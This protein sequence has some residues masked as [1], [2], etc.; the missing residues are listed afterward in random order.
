MFTRTR[1]NFAALAAISGA[2]LAAPVHAQ[3]PQR[4]EV[5]GSRIKR[6]NAEL[7]SPVETITA[8]D[9]Q[10]TGAKTVLE[11]MRTVPA[12]G[13]DGYNDT[14]LQNGF[15]RGVATASLRSLSSTSTL[16]LLNGRRITPSA[17]ANPNNGTST[18]Y[19]LNSIPVSALER[20]EVFKDGASAVYGSDAVGGVI[21]FIT[22]RSYQGLELGALTAFNDEGEFRKSGFNITGGFGDYESTGFNIMGSLD[23]KRRGRTSIYDGDADIAADDYRAIN[24]RRNVHGSGLTQASPIF[25][26]ES[27][28]GNRSFP[29][30][31]ASAKV[32]IPLNCNE[33]RQLVGGTEHGLTTASALFG[34]RFCNYSLNDFDE[35]QTKGEDVSLISRAVLKLGSSASAFAEIGGSQSKRYFTGAPRA[36]SGL[37]PT[38]NFLTGGLAP[39]FQAIL[40]VGHPDN[41]FNAEG[42]RAAVAIRNENSRGGNDLTNSQARVLVGA[43]GLLASWDWETAILWNRSERKETSYGFFQLPVLRQ[44]LGAPGPTSGRSLASVFADPGL[45]RPLTNRGEASILQWD[46]RVSTEFARLPGGPIGFASGVE[47]RREE[48]DI[49]PD[50][51]NANGDVLGLATTA[52]KGSRDVKSAFIEFRFPVLK[53]LEIDAAGRAD[54]YPG[55]KTSFVPKVGAKWTILPE[56]ALR[57]SYSEGFRAPA[58]SQVSP[59]GA[60]FFVNNLIDP[61]RCEEDG[62]TPRPG[63]VASDCAKSASGVGGANPALKPEESRSY[64]VGLILSPARGF[65]MLI[66]YYKI[67]KIGEVA[68]GSAED[69]IN[70]PERYPPGSLVRDDNPALLLNGVAGTGPLLSVSLPWINQG[71]TEVNGID[72]EGRLQI[73]LAWAKR[74]TVGFRGSYLIRYSRQ[75]D[76]SYP[77]NN[78]AGTNGGLSDWATSAGDLPRAKWRLSASME[79]GAHA[80][81][82]AVN[83]I[84]GVHFLRESDGSQSPPATFSGSTC[85]WGGPNNDGAALVGRSIL[86]VAPTATNGR[87]LYF[88]R[89]PECRVPSWTTL[90]VGYTY[91]GFKGLDL[92]LQVANLL[93]KAAPYY[94]GTN[95]SETVYLGHRAQLHNGYGRYFTLSANYKF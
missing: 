26:R 61:V 68:L 67:R 25:Y 39:S 55:I 40:E 41:P 95:T 76:I 62:I 56:V 51:A 28:P 14:P 84:S 59:G 43:Q 11:L 79:R 29:Q 16:I 90:D 27:A 13:Y 91:S 22:K 57:G 23:V 83:H 4:V 81:D 75:E 31:G 47:L 77:E 7:S 33:S 3:D 69:V 21:N 73:P 70:H 82:A 85:H 17:Y 18:L 12:V 46:G 72:V 94:P 52:V 32:E 2:I 89:H 5:T 50:P 49:K 71:A 48:I 86:G 24:V 34:K 64:N 30:V 15:S 36:I 53:S 66:D 87:D 78:L 44:I 10:A 38:T 74:F 92:R 20:V 42:R 58:V 6:V 35:L 9:I 88:N 60:Q 63:A 45:S 80:F 65:D 19:D 93:D 1:V 8:A 54:K 37:S